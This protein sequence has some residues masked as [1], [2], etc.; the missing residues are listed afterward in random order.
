MSCCDNVFLDE[1]PVF[2]KGLHEDKLSALYA[3][4]QF[5]DRGVFEVRSP[6]QEIPLDRARLMISN[7]GPEIR[8]LNSHARELRRIITERVASEES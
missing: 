4:I 5:R 8:R 2:A 1:A 6:L 3:D 7:Y